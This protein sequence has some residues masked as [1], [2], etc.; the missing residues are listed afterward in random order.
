M[1]ILTRQVHER[2]L[3]KCIATSLIRHLGYSDKVGKSNDRTNALLH[4]GSPM[5]EQLN[6][7][8]TKITKSSK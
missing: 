5:T 4:D 7:M 1:A 6:Q 3:S 2:Y 8:A